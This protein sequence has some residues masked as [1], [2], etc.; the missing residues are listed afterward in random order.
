M[1][2]RHFM[3]A[4]SSFKG[5]S[6]LTVIPTVE[7]V[8][9]ISMLSLMEVGIPKSGGRNLSTSHSSSR[10]QFFLPDSRLALSHSLALVRAKSKYSSVIMQLL[11]PIVQALSAYMASRTSEVIFPE[12][13]C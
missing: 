13:R 7:Q 2:F 9:C 1:F 5:F 12:L 3:V 4:Q 6:A 11:T 10:V 8:P